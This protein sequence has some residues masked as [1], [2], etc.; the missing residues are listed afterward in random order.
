MTG[1]P[2]SVLQYL[3]C[4][5]QSQSVDAYLSKISAVGQDVQKC[6][7]LVAHQQL[8]SKLQNTNESQLEDLKSLFSQLDGPI[9]RSATQITDLHD[10]LKE[11]QRLKLFDWL[12]TVPYQTHHR[13]MGRDFSEGSC[14]WLRQ[15][16]EFMEWRKS[17]VSSVLWLHGIPGCG[18]SKS[19]Y[20]VIKCIRDENALSAA[21]APIAYFF[22]V[23]N[24]AEPERADPEVIMR[25]ILK[26]LSCSSSDLP[27]R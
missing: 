22:C 24:N 16:P 12:S 25:S 4:K 21:P 19:I 10:A 13:T 11:N 20:S 9:Y 15:S 2:F 1:K 7:T 8:T 23:R 6:I 3:W 14:K 26:Q 17:S 27:V 5:A 18:K